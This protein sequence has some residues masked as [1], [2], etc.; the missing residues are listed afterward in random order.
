MAIRMTAMETPTPMPA[1]APVLKLPPPF[2]DESADEVGD[3]RLEGRF[4]ARRV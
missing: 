3:E 2:P 4:S 1:D